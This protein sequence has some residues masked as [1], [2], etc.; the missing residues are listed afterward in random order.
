[1]RNLIDIVESLDAPSSQILTQAIKNKVAEYLQQ[2]HAPNEFRIN[3]GLC[4]DFAEEVVDELG[5]E[6]DDFFTIWG[7]ELTK[8]GSDGFADQQ[9]WD[10][11]LVQRISPKSHPTHNLTW[12]DVDGDIPNHCWIVLN[13]RHYDAE[14]PEGVDN[15]FDL[16]ICRRT[17]REIL[18]DKAKVSKNKERIHA[19]IEQLDSQVND[20]KAHWSPNVNKDEEI[21]VFANYAER[22]A[23]LVTQLNSLTESV[24][25]TPDFDKAANALYKDLPNN[26]LSSVRAFV[27]MEAGYEPYGKEIISNEDDLIKQWC[28]DK[29]HDVYYEHFYQSV[30]SGKIE[31]WRAITAPQ[32][33]KPEHW[34]HLGIY[35]CWQENH[36]E[37]YWGQASNQGGAN[38]HNYIIHAFLPVESIDW[39]NTLKMNANP[40]YEHEY[41]IRIH[42]NSAVEVLNIE[43][44]GPVNA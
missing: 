12:D 29:I 44:K 25:N 31:A 2:G 9:N 20:L 4:E 8:V 26:G 18:I 37:A 27:R 14:C 3:N 33:W 1:M 38:N 6:T 41:E 16:P 28:I 43:D 13:G 17:I 35:W 42:P 11:E 30:R 10:R 24:G 7:I 40:D 19:A 39:I 15:L 23:E 22:R 5:G 34:E 32:N 21:K 36:A